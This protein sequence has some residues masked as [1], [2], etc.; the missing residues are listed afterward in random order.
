MNC[1]DNGVGGSR[2]S[3]PAIA[4]STTYSS[5]MMEDPNSIHKHWIMDTADLIFTN[6]LKD[7]K[8]VKEKFKVNEGE[9]SYSMMEHLSLT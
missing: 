8:L 7:L 5:S 3:S 6:A 2:I 4:I 1:R 9:S